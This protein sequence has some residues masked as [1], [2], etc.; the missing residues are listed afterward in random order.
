MKTAGRQLKTNSVGNPKKECEIELYVYECIA[1][2]DLY[3]PGSVGMESIEYQLIRVLYQQSVLVTDYMRPI[4][5]LKALWRISFNNLYFFIL[6][7]QHNFWFISINLW[8]NKLLHLLF[9]ITNFITNTWKNHN[10]FTE[11]NTIIIVKLISLRFSISYTD[12]DLFG[13][14]LD[15]RVLE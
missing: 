15:K 4:E 6:F 3:F 8:K 5:I 2:S 12:M 1:W 11:Y 14:W 10:T 13:V 9:R 7:F